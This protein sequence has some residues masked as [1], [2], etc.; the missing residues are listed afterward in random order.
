M[1]KYAIGLLTL[2]GL[3]IVL[4]IGSLATA[5]SGQNQVK[6]DTLNS[7]QEG[8]AIVSTGTGTFEAQIND[9]T[10]TIT[11]TLTYEALE[12]GTPTQAHIHIGKRAENGGVSA[13]LCA[14]DKPACP[15]SGTVTGEITPANVVGPAAQGVEPG[16]WGE[17]VR[18]LRSGNTYVNVHNARWPGGE[19][20]AQIN[21]FNQRETG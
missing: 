19:I 1:R 8:P 11:Y 17:L 7:Y 18:A 10:Q 2:V 5:G 9:D 14:G 6:A 3:A 21:D 15:P 16:S 13:F 20:R 4:V 12:G